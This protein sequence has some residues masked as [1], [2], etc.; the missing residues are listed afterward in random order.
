M[1]EEKLIICYKLENYTDWH[2]LFS[3]SPG[4][5][6]EM[7]R[8]S[9]AAYEFPN[10]SEWQK[11]I[12]EGLF[13]I[14]EKFDWTEFVETNKNQVGLNN[15]SL[16]FLLHLHSKIILYIITNYLNFIWLAVWYLTVRILFLFVC[17]PSALDV[18]CVACLS[19][20]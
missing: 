11:L 3:Q 7:K 19:F 10:G 2:P 13:T 15:T 16:A 14:D 1:K 18:L 17:A 9:L 12:N 8:E 6:A 20:L 4:Y 5:S